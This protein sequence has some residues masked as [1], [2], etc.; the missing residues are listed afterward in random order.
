MTQSSN[1]I[2]R[3]PVH[4]FLIAVGLIMLAV[5]GGSIAT[6]GYNAMNQALR[7]ALED[8]FD[9]LTILMRERGRRLVDPIG[10]QLG[11]LIHDPLSSAT[12]LEGRL[13]RLPVL[14]ETLRMN[15]TVVS[16]YA[17]YP[18]GDFILVRKIETDEDVSRFNA[19]EGTR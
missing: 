17:G 16:V 12:S 5:V 1:G 18:N 13:A 15:G 2:F 14:A 11:V 7:A 6:L 10:A 4:V 8:Q 9:S 19:P 3:V